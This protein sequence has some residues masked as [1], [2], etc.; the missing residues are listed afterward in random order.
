MGGGRKLCFGDACF[1]DGLGHLSHGF[2][3]PPHHRITRPKHI[4][5]CAPQ[6]ESMAAVAPPTTETHLQNTVFLTPPN[7]NPCLRCHGSPPKHISKTQF[8]LRLQI[9]IHGFG[10]LT[11]YSSNENPWLRWPGPPPKRTSETLI[12]LCLPI[13]IHS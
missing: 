3:C 13:Q 4:V 10:H 6:S 1:G 12:S 2:G 11:D 9:N 7:Q 5:P 8:S